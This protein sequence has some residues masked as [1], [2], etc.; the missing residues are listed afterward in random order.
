MFLSDG[1]DRFHEHR[2]MFRFSFYQFG[3]IEANHH[4]INLKW[5]DDEIVKQVI[6]VKQHVS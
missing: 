4:I 6:S 1:L 3:K 5:K 2:I